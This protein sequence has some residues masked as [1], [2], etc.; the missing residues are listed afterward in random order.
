MESKSGINKEGHPG[1][2]V[3]GDFSLIDEI[4]SIT[5]TVVMNSMNFNS[6]FIFRKNFRVQKSYSLSTTRKR[7]V[8]EPISN[9]YN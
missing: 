9:Y 6:K 4:T 8:S 2:R 7:C 1:R 5:N 3:L